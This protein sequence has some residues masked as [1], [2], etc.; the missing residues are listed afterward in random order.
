M[1]EHVYVNTVI[2]I[3]TFQKA[4][5]QRKNATRDIL[6]LVISVT[7]QARSRYSLSA[8]DLISHRR[9]ARLHSVGLIEC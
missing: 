6:L 8:W 1:A 7:I 4:M 5:K 3:R 2:P 9:I